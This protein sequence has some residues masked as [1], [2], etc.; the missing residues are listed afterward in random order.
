MPNT[1]PDAVVHVAVGVIQDRAGRVL[2]TRRPATAHQ[3]GLWEFPG[4]K[5]DAGESVQEALVRELREELG[6]EVSAARPLMRVSHAYADKAVLLDV[7]RISTVAGQARGCEG[8]PVRWVAVK[9]LGS[10][11]FPEANRPIV[12]ALQLPRLYLITDSRRGGGEPFLKRLEIALEAG[13]SLIQLREPH[14]GEQDYQALAREVCRLAHRYDARV[15]LNAEPEWVRACGADGVHL[16]SRRLRELNHRPLP[17]ELLVAA[18]CHDEGELKQAVAIHAD[19]A[20]LSPV[21]KTASHPDV[22]PLGW[23]RFRRLCEKEPLP[24]YAL[25]GMGPGDIIDA[26]A[27]GA[28]GIA[29]I[30]AIWEARSIAEAVAGCQR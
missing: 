2:I 5:I 21:L 27:A 18:S 6:V 11:A 29:A 12:R 8:Q 14:L 16:N 7:W 1:A 28:Q 22:V 20:V 9:D 17:Q 13:A 3:G 23:E 4:G 24:L 25:G 19:F 30:R 15:L 10:F 26:L